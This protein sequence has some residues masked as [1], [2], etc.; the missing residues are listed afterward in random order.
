MDTIEA[1]VDDSGNV[2]EAWEAYTVP[3][4]SVPQGSIPQFQK[5]HIGFDTAGTIIVSYLVVKDNP[6]ILSLTKESVSCCHRSKED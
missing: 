4:N 3:T 1:G 2:A 6:G 5:T